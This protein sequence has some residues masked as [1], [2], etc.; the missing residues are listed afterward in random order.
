MAMTMLHAARNTMLIVIRGTLARQVRGNLDGWMGWMKCPSVSS[1]PKKQELEQK[2]KQKQEWAYDFQYN[3]ATGE[4]GATREFPGRVHQGVYDVFSKIRDSILAEVERFRPQHV[5]VTGHS[6]GGALTHLT[7]YAV[8]TRFPGVRV[9]G[10]SFASIL[11]GDETF[12]R[13]VKVGGRLSSVCGMVARP[14]VGL[15]RIT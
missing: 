1:P 11:V 12:M 13:E 7:S 4:S 6:L 14:L 2:Q 9:D 15:I 10:V 3:F 8:A 5:F